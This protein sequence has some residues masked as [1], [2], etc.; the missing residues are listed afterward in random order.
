MIRRALR[1]ARKGHLVRHH[2][3]GADR[4]ADA[5]NRGGA[6]VDRRSGRF[7][8]RPAQLNRGT[9]CGARLYVGDRE[10]TGR[11]GRAAIARADD[12]GAAAEADTQRNESCKYYE[13]R[14]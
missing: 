13:R 2:H 14:K 12:A 4:G 6:V 9:R 8:C 10:A 11:I 1:Q 3:R 5:I 7:V